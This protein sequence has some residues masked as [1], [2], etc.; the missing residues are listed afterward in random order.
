MT[1]TDGGP[2]RCESGD[3]RQAREAVASTRLKASNCLSVK[4]SG[5]DRICETVR[6][7]SPEETLGVSEIG[8]ET[9]HQ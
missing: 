9:G 3:A 2:T 7:L 1:I 6:E 8:T 5:K 4:S